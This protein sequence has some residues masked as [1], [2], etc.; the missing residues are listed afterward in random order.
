MNELPTEFGIMLSKLYSINKSIVWELLWISLSNNSSLIAWFI[1]KCDFSKPY[2][3]DILDCMLNEDFPEYTNTVRENV[4]K[5]FINTLKESPLSSTIPVGVLEKNGNKLSVTRMA[6]NE[7]S[8]V[9]VGLYRFCPWIAHAKTVSQISPSN[10]T[11][12]KIKV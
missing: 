11:L 8:F 7:I 6:H 3:R 12:F 1:E 5:A 2:G 10:G 9:S 4:M